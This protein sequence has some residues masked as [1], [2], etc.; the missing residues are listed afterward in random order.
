MFQKNDRALITART[1][2]L[3]VVII[4]AVG[5]F[6]MGLALAIAIR[7]VLFL[8]AFAGWFL[9]WLAWVFV[10]LHLSYLCDI[11]LIR[12]KLYGESNAGLEVF[13]SSDSSGT[14][15]EVRAVNRELSEI[16][17]LLSSGEITNEEYEKRKKELEKRK[18]ELTNEER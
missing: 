1:I 13:L 14:N 9:C 16:Y 17:S 6:T 2:T 5:S 3:I 7:P 11:K 10:R 15:E 12:N 18:N 8:T 4:L